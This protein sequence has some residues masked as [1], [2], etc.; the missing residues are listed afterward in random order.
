M[1]WQLEQRFPHC[2]YTV[3]LML[4]VP[5]SHVKT[6]QCYYFCGADTQADYGGRRVFAL[7]N[8]TLASTTEAHSL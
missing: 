4:Y 6:L 3:L 2:I 1:V 7:L 5:E 8:S